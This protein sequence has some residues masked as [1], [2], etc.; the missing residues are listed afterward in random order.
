MHTYR[1]QWRDPG[2][3]PR[4][5]EFTIPSKG[6]EIRT[7]IEYNDA[8]SIRRLEELNLR[9]FHQRK[10]KRKKNSVYTYRAQWHGLNDDASKTMTLFD[11][12]VAS[13]SRTRSKP[14]A[15]NHQL[16]GVPMLL[17]SA[18]LFERIE[19]TIIIPRTVNVKR[20]AGWMR[21]LI[22]TRQGRP[23]NNK[24]ARLIH[25]TFIFVTRERL[26]SKFEQ[27]LLG[28]SDCVGFVVDTE[29]TT[30]C[31]LSFFHSRRKI[32]IFFFFLFFLFFLNF[33]KFHRKSYS[34][35]GRD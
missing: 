24:I 9:Q 3:M 16:R 7:L 34:Q 32:I 10:K 5:I 17:I 26:F 13:D 22:I 2:T 11:R 15:M 31:N 6:K 20:H 19:Q 25:E 29:Y 4:R 21:R 1:A 35:S 28:L 33:F 14:R 12:I 23:S 18:R 27:L 30:R 8:V